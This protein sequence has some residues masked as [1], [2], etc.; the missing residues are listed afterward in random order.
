MAANGEL[1]GGPPLE[2]RLRNLI[3]SHSE[4]P[5]A[6]KPPLQGPVSQSSASP[7][8]ETPPSLSSPSS[9]GGLASR[10]SRKRPNQAQRRQMSAQLSIPIDTRPQNQLP[11]RPYGGRGHGR[12][13]YHRGQEPRSATFRPP[14]LGNEMPNA[15]LTAMPFPCRPRHQPSHSYQGPMAARKSQLGLPQPP[16]HRGDPI[17]PYQMPGMSSVPPRPSD[18]RSQIRQGQGA[19]DIN[20]RGRQFNGPGEEVLMAQAELLESLCRTIVADAEIETSEIMEK[21]GFRLKIEAV[22]QFVIT[23]HERTQNDFL[24]FPPESVQLKCFGSLASGFATKASD[25]DLGLLSP[26]SRIQPDAPGSPIPRLVEKAFLEIGL[27]A[28]LLTQTRVPII[29][30]CEKPPEELRL[31]LLAERAKWERG[32][33]EDHDEDEASGAQDSHAAGGSQPAE[34]QAQGD[35]LTGEQRLQ[36]FKQNGS[37]GLSAYNSYHGSAKRLLRKLGG[38]DMTHSNAGDFSA[39]DVKLLNQVCLAFVEGLADSNLRDRLLRYRSLNRYDLSSPKNCRTLL[40]VL[41]QVEGEHMAL[42]W[43][44]RPFR[45]RDESRNAAAEAAVRLWRAL[46]DSPDYGRDPLVYQKELQ[47]AVERM[48]RISSIQVLLLAQAQGESAANYCSR[49]VRLLQDLGGNDSRARA[50]TLLP[51]T[52]EHYV[53]G[54]YN[55]TI[56]QQVKDFQQAHGISNLRAIGRAHKSLQL[57]VEYEACLAKGLYH[58]QDAARVRQYIDFLRAPAAQTSPGG[59]LSGV[60]PLPP[61]SASLLAN[62]RQ[63][64][65]PSRAAPNQPRDRYSSALEFPK[66]G[67]GVQCDINFSAHLAVQNT[68]LL[69][70]YS[71]CDPRVRPLVLFVKHWAKVRRINTPYRGT[72]GSYGYS[73]MM[74]HYLVNIAQPFV[75][76][77]LQQLARPPD[78]ALAPQQ[79]EET[80]LCKGRNIQFWRDEA[81]IVRLARDNALTQNRESVGELLRGFFEYYAKGGPPMATLPCRSFDWGRDVISLRTHGGLLS[82]QAKGWTGAKTVVES[83]SSAAAPPPPQNSTSLLLPNRESSHDPGSTPPTSSAAAAAA[84]PSQQQAKAQQNKNVEVKEVRYRYLFAIE[85]PFELD[86]N[87]ARTVT[88]AGI[89]NIRDEFRRAWRIIRN[90]GRQAGPGSAAAAAG[91]GSGDGRTGGGVGGGARGGQGQHDG[92]KQEDLLEDVGRAEEAREMEVFDRLL[93]ELHGVRFHGTGVTEGVGGDDGE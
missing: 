43:E 33:N 29:K 47:L 10:A 52:I 69:R 28:R 38:R 1:G 18:S 9:R 23:E 16:M 64:G 60:I 55:P 39:E 78:P 21:E 85:D 72:L 35:G 37:S 49:A 93:E 86:H 53:G 30:V 54:I 70:C 19:P 44:S 66:S 46:Q 42:L 3:L 5:S 91:D 27:G 45:E 31:A 26:L 36:G 71:H 7:G 67:V 32:A 82:K 65:D 63:L 73:L 90:A 50:D 11:Q 84:A 34:S 40:G 25:M 56:R 15:P 2:D 74:L 48:K 6:T 14:S 4:G 20:T 24:D 77:N 76:P 88:H 58:E 61:G 12:D 80:L 68:L 81:E 89:V 92:W 87:V 57:A 75:C 51:T 62:I 13:G 83:S 17:L 8:P 22:A 59:H 41:T 79:A